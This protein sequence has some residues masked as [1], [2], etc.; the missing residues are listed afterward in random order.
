M[1]R[2]GYA[3][4]LIALVAVLPAAGA[5][6]AQHAG[7]SGT[8]TDTTGNA[9]PGVT[10]EL[11]G[12]AAHGGVQLVVTDGRGIFSARLQPGTYDVTFTLPGFHAVACKEVVVAT[13]A[14]ATVDAEL[15][16]ES[17]R[18]CAPVHAQSE[19][20]LAEMRAAAEG[21]DADAQ[22]QL[23]LQLQSGQV[24]PR[25]DVEAAAWLLRA[26]EQNHMDA[27]FMLGTMYGQ[28][29]GVPR[30]AVEA[31]AWTRTAAEAGH[32]DAQ[33]VLGLLY[34][35]GRGVIQDKVL[36]CMWHILAA[37]RSGDRNREFYAEAL[38][39]QTKLLTRAE[40]REARRLAREWNETHPRN[41]EAG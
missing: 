15:A 22:Y 35:Q 4:I 30:D 27:Q 26:A 9:L 21:G 8:V 28:G 3:S 32:P 25:D 29:R 13:G 19:P 39:H 7:I 38:K 11:R 12:A 33:F 2:Y 1:Q 18:S 31:A 41:G 24:V 10:V 5:V 17:P 23:A 40:Q 20:W 37:S 6:G 14:F 36:A 16:V 34:G